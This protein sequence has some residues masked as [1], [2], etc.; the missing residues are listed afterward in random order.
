M[1]PLVTGFVLVIIV[2]CSVIFYRQ[3]VRKKTTYI[4]TQHKEKR[5]MQ[6]YY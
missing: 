2:C 4:S 3:R 1:I 5:I 6:A